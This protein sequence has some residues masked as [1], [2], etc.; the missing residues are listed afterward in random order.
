[1]NGKMILLQDCERRGTT[2]SGAGNNLGFTCTL[3]GKVKNK[4]NEEEEEEEKKEMQEII[5]TTQI[6]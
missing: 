4:K 2:T 1:M 5:N 6:P 3:P